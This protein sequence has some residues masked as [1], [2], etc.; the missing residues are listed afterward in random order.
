MVESG[1]IMLPQR[2]IYEKVHRATHQYFAAHGLIAQHVED[3]RTVWRITPKG[4]AVHAQGGQ[5]PVESTPPE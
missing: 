1:W 4:L 2:G 3:T 5:L